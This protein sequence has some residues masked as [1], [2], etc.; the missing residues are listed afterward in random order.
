MT[1]T[2][3]TNDRQCLSGDHCHGYDHLAKHPAW[4]DGGSPLCDVC[5]TT[6]ARD[7]GMLTVDW[8]DLEQ[9]QLPALSQAMN[10]QPGSR[11]DPPMPLRGEPEA[12]QREIHHVTTTWE[13]LVRNAAG[14]AD[15]PELAR[16]GRAVQRAVTVLQPRLRLLACLPATA[17]YPTGCEDQPADVAGW[18]AVHHLQR[19]RGR[20]RAMLGWTHRSRW[21]PGDC[22]HCDGRDDDPQDGPLYR[23]EPRFEEDDCRVYCDR[24]G[25]HRREVDYDTYLLTLRWPGQLESAAE[26]AEPAEASR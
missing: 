23:A 25:R 16:H 7:V 20:A 26:P 21:V 17:V 2:P 18:E 5:L 10:T 8:L 3:A 19:L 14:L 1:D 9:Q 13:A 24:C 15:L 11:R 22:W 6:A 12:L 4:T